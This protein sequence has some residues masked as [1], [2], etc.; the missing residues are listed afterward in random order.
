VLKKG[1]M[2]SNTCSQYAE[3]RGLLVGNL[4]RKRLLRRPRLGWGIKFILKKEK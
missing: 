1:V 3:P 2:I 4:E